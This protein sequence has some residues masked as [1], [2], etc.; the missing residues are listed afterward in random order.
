QATRDP[1]F[2]A[3]FAIANQDANGAGELCLRC[4]APGAWLAGRSTPPDGVALDSTVGDFDG[5]TCH[6][7]HRMVDPVFTP[8]VNPSIDERILNA[9]PEVP[10]T[11]SNGQYVIDPRDV[12]RGPF[13]LG[14]NF[15]FHE[16]LQ[17]PFH[18]ESLLCAN[19]HD[20]SNPTLSKQPD[21]SY[22]L[23]ANNT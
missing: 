20:V 8:G 6:L 17:S 10:I 4:H 5:V 16:W 23:N 21:G 11:P 7:C 22:Q 18:L 13:Q 15:F 14:P 12:R 3:A 19:C 1:V 2:H 9:L